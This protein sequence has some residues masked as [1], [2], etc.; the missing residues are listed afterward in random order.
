MEF[1]WG[2]RCRL[3]CSRDLGLGIL[4]MSIGDWKVLILC[5]YGIRLSIEEVTVYTLRRLRRTSS[6]IHAVTTSS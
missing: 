5:E 4:E 6:P 2:R 1:L 3:A